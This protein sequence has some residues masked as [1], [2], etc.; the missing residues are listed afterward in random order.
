MVSIVEANTDGLV[1]KAKALFKEY[2]KSLNFDL[3]FQNFDQELKD[4]PGQYSSPSGG[5]FL[6]IEE[7]TAIGCVGFRL[8]ED[9]A[10]EMKRLYVKPEFR[11]R[12]L[13][14]CYVF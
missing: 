4:F 14:G 8:L 5:L 12:S 13:H 3:C 9:Q 6:A 11:K 1:T 7:D 10:C 2:A